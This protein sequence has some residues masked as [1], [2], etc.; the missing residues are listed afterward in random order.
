VALI[1]AQGMVVAAIAVMTTLWYFDLVARK[2]PVV[3]STLQ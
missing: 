1:V 2:E 3:T